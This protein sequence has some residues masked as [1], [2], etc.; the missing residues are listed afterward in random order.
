MNQNDPHVAHKDPCV[1]HYDPRVDQEKDPHVD[2]SNPH[3]DQS[4]PHVDCNDPHVDRREPD[5]IFFLQCGKLGGK[6]FGGNI[7]PYNFVYVGLMVK[8]IYGLI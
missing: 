3:V 6:Y 4:E 2:H 8:L 1:D 5:E 7:D